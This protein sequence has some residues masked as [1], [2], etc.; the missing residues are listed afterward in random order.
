MPM[1]ADIC[2]ITL[3]AGAGSRMPDDMP[4]KP[5][6]KIGP[7]SVIE[8]ALESYEQAGIARHVVV[9]GCQADQ[10]M[11]EVSRT[12][13]QALFAYQDRPRGTGDAV[14]CAL[15]LLDSTVTPEHVLI[16]TGDRVIAPYLIRGLLESYAASGRPLCL[17]TGPA[18]H[19]PTSGRVVQ[20]DGRVLA[21]VEVPDIRVRQMARRLRSLEPKERPTTGAE[22][23]ELA[24]DYLPARKLASYCPELAALMDGPGDAPLD[25]KRV[26]EAMANLPEHFD[27]PSGAITSEEAEAAE[28]A[29]M[30]VYVGRF[31]RLT[32][33]VATLGTD[34][35]QDEC[36]FTDVVAQLA[37]AGDEVGAY[38]APD[39]EDVM[40]FNTA[41]ELEAIRRIHAVRTQGRRPY[42]SVQE[43]ASYLESRDPDSLPATA[44][45][46]LA[47]K[48]AP[49]K[50]C[51]LARAPGRVNLMGRHIDH[52]GGTC[53]LMAIDQEI[54]MAAS[55]RPDDRIRLW[56]LESGSYPARSFTLRELTAD[57]VWED[58]LRTLDLQY[59][60]RLASR[61]AGDWT[62]YVMGAA[63]RLQHYFRDRQLRGMDAFVCGNIP[64]GAGLSSSS[65]LVMAS[66]EALSEINALNIRPREFVDLCGEGEWFVG[67]RGGSGDHAA[68]MFGQEQEVVSISFFPFQV[69]GRHPFPDD[70][71][72]MVCHSGLSA[73]KTEN[74]RE[75]FNARVGCYHMAREIVRQQFPA[76]AP[77]IEH[78]RDINTEQLDIT[79]PA[80]YSLLKS[81]PAAAGP[82]QVEEL[83]G[84]HESVAKCVKG[85]DLPSL[86]FPLR[87]VA[88]YGLAECARSL[89]TGV[90]LD[91][92]DME[93]LG[94][95]MNISHD[96]DRVARWQPDRLPYANKTT[97]ERLE[98]LIEASSS[99]RPLEDSSAA[100]WQQ[101]GAYGCSMPGI[102]LMVD[103]VLECPGVMGAQL[104][105]AGLGGCIMVL[106]RNGR[107][108]QVR[109][110]LEESYYGPREIEPQ[111][112]VCRPSRGCR[113]VTSL[114]AAP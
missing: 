19:N 84:E 87:D 57:V 41:E 93:L 47:G 109:E 88:M 54:V 101:P 70:C 83:A 97:D 69:V 90:L 14:R 53:N 71:S 3:A 44:V 8:N 26:T 11:D 56:N 17:L 58:W 104:A 73:K 100:L 30:S 75:R 76:F 65:A 23:C 15:E 78:L 80:L 82:Q 5:C 79:L 29:N 113:V 39:P 33:A 48:I 22:L 105:G 12:G 18:D 107:T 108:G 27:L 16:S 31:D 50:P 4:P 114:E 102:D 21:I 25:W 77:R 49:H 40:A 96:G 35:V 6:C 52:Q 68:I 37:A 66:A 28:F 24:T 20:R 42:P 72:L 55:P 99:L 103:R 62:S 112:F 38:F 91:R 85:L 51:I 10:V 59:V 98:R 32:E 67:T 36:Y 1:K 63:L 106:V 7:V 89:R 81:L 92:G 9:V 94:R 46:G 34:N 74:A 2:S 64:V 13:R 43:W 60:Q 110:V 86:E 61:T 95:M 111:T 45:R